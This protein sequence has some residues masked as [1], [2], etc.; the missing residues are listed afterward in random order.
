NA[1]IGVPDDRKGEK[2]ILY[3][4]KK[5]AQKQQLREYI[6][7]AR[8][9]MLV[10]PAEVIVLEK[11]PLLGSGKTDYVTLKADALKER[12]TDVS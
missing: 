5:E 7:Q 11:L 1:A 2:I 8:Q 10:M 12:E 3:T 6:G 4:T 9:N